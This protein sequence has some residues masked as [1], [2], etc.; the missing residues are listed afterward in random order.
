MELAF[1]GSGDR[2]TLRFPSPFLRSEPTSL[3]VEAQDGDA[4]V[5]KSIGVSH[6]EAFKRE[7]EHFYQCIVDGRQPVTSGHEGRQDLVVLQAIATALATGRSQAIPPP[8]A[9]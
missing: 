2:V 3:V 8:A 4:P 5:R 9:L 7:L 6:D 1:Y